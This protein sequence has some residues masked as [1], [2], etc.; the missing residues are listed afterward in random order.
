MNPLSRRFV[1]KM[2]LVHLV[3]LVGLVVM[4]A[5]ATRLVYNSFR[6]EAIRAVQGRQHLLAIQTTRGI[7]NYYESIQNVLDLLSRWNENSP[8]RAA[9]AA[10][11]GPPAARIWTLAP[12]MWNQLEGRASHLFAL[13]P[14]NMDVLKSFSTENAPKGSAERIARGN[15]RWLGQV[16][17][18]AVSRLVKIDEHRATLVAVPV[19]GSP[20]L[21]LVAVVPVERIDAQFLDRLSSGHQ[22]LS[23]MLLDDGGGILA[24][25]QPQLFAAHPPGDLDD[26]HLAAQ[27][28]QFLELGRSG[29]QSFNTPLPNEAIALLPTI[30]TA[31]PV[32]VG[33]HNWWLVISSSLSYVD[34]V[35]DHLF[36]QII[37]WSVFVILSMTALLVSS[38]IT[39]LR[40]RF[41]LERLR[42]EML[43]QEIEQARD[44][45]LAWL[46]AR[47]QTLGRVDVAAINHPASHI[48]GDF[49]NWF[50]L[51]DGRLA[52]CVGDVTGHGM[53]AAFLMATTQLMARTTMMRLKDP[54]RAMQEINRQLC[55]QVFRG[56]FVTMLILV[57]D[58]EN[59]RM[60]A[61]TAGHYPPLLSDGGPFEP[62]G[63]C[64]QL[65]LG[66]Q[67]GL[68][69]PTE[70]FDLPNEA[71]MLLYTDGVLD[72][73]APDGRRF[74]QE[75]IQAA[76]AGPFDSAEGMIEGVVTALKQF[77]NGRPPADD[78]TL[79][80]IHL[81]GVGR[82]V[83]TTSAAAD[84]ADHTAS[85][86][87]S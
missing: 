2:L 25:S 8:G 54:G 65:I 32:H 37:W 71:T 22:P 40:G 68:K 52:I 47:S 74:D 66:V 33:G 81:N 44:I 60:E 82:A 9:A 45:Q 4:L 17:G 26:P 86:T 10:A 53:A 77:C 50:E 80:A 56:Q 58:L 41:R 84:E 5:I 76:L 34:E 73:Q 28:R 23:A 24:F 38:F 57:L 14:A 78:L 64:P 69:Y 59:N 1:W 36:G 72:A 87:A 30:T 12:L 83:D 3:L 15:G 79:V 55:T 27:A 39:V 46:P 6:Q 13:N 51:D 75:K 35:I 61:A 67:P 85:V 42:H 49:Y 21:L 63:I 18:P 11:I 43:T 48:S 19:G 7:E 70:Y 16:H 62:M 31:F 29:R 20:K